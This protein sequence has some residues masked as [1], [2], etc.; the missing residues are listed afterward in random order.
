MWNRNGRLLLPPGAESAPEITDT[1]LCRFSF[2]E[3]FY[4]TAI[5]HSTAIYESTS[6]TSGT[7]SN[8]RHTVI[9]DT[10]EIAADN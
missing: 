3:S 2:A 10:S 4:S 7:G 1:N 6:A 5:F 9:V 8:L